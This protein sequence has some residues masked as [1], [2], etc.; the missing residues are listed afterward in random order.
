MLREAVKCNLT[1][2]LRSDTIYDSEN[3]NG[4]VYM[5][6]EEIVKKFVKKR[7]VFRIMDMSSIVIM[8]VF[9]IIANGFFHSQVNGPYQDMYVSI[10]MVLFIWGLILTLY[11]GT[12]LSRCP[13]CHKDLKTLQTSQSARRLS[14]SVDPLPNY[15]PY[16]GADFSKYNKY[17]M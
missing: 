10:I 12:A 16:C 15:C 11:V 4:G 13:L 6:N 7:T 3:T 8:L 9:A 5:D 17:K 14:I 2:A 1:S